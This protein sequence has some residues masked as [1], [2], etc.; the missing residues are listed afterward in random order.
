MCKLRGQ[1]PG[2]VFVSHHIRNEACRSRACIADL[3]T[4]E[5]VRHTGS[6]IGPKSFENPFE[7]RFANMEFRTLSPRVNR[8]PKRKCEKQL[9]TREET[10]EM[11]FSEDIVQRVWEKALTVPGYNPKEWRKD[12]CKAWI[13]REQYGNRN[14][15]Y[16][17]EIDHITPLSEGG[18]DDLSNL[19]PLQ[20]ENNATKQAAR[21]TCPVTASNRKNV[22]RT[23]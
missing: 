16:G 12:E 19:R 10:V 9:G 14:S 4:C 3:D 11:S 1:T 6:W 23:Q 2:A 21:L 7:T 20:W 17:W 5:G 15:D 18:T 22:R 13:H 8:T